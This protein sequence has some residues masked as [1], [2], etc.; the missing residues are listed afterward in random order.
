M[1]DGEGEETGA[2]DDIARVRF[3]EEG[4]EVTDKGLKAEEPTAQSGI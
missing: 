1:T 4:E 3:A 2:A